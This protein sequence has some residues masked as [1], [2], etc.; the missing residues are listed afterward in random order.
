MNGGCFNGQIITFYAMCIL[1]MKAGR[2]QMTY[3]TD[4]GGTIYKQWINTQ[5]CSGLDEG[6]ISPSGCIGLYLYFIGS[7][8]AEKEIEVDLP[9]SQVY[10][11]L[12]GCTTGSTGKSVPDH[13][14]LAL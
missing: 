14:Q 13:T 7:A 10:V 9:P 3:L 5:A 12:S 11:S 6:D 8:P 2:L 4:C 1:I